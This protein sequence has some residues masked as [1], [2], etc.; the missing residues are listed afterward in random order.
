MKKVHLLSFIIHYSLFII[1]FFFFSLPIH[2][3]TTIDLSGQWQFQIDRNDRGITEGW[4]APDYKFDDSI[5][6][7]ASMPQRLKGDDISVDTK[8]VGSLYDSSYFFNPYMKKYRNPGKDMKL[9]FFLTPDKHYVGVAWYKKTVHIDD[10]ES[11]PLYTLYL[12]RPH[13]T[14]QVWVN[15]EQVSAEQNSLSVPHKHFLYGYLKP[16]DNTIAIRVN[17]DP[18]TVKVGQDSHSVSDQTQGDWNGLVG[19][20][21]LQPFNYIDN[22]KVYPDVDSKTARIHLDLQ[23]LQK[24]ESAIITLKATPFNTTSNFSSQVIVAQ[25]QT[26]ILTDLTSTTKDITLSLGDNMLLWD[27]F[28]PNL[29]R[30]DIE[31]KTKD[32][33][34][35]SSTVFGMRKIEI[36]DK[37]FYV[38]GNEIQLRG[39]V[40]NCDFPLTGYPPTDLESWL[41]V[42]CTCKSYGLNHMR[43]HSYCPPEAAFLAADMVGFYIQPEGPSWPN[44]GVKLGQG[45]PIDTYLMEEALAISDVY[46]NH[47]SFTMFCFGNEPAGNWVKWATEHT[48]KMKVWDDRRVYGGFSVGGGWAWQPGSEYQVKAGARGLNEW[49]KRAPESM[50]D[51]RNNIA[52]YNGKD[53]PGTKIE[54]PYVSHET[55]Q[56][57]A[58]PNFDEIS[59]YSGV[60]KAK[61]FEI[62]RD[63]LRDN[64]MESRAHDFLMA[65]GKL[66][67]ICYKAEIERTLRTP[68]YAGFQLLSLNDYSGQGTA[69]VGLTDVFFDDK[70]YINSTEFSEFCSSV[71]PLARI[72]KFTYTNDEKFEAS[73][74]L[75]QF[76]GTTLKG[77][78]PHWV[79]FKEPSHRTIDGIHSTKGALNMEA[80]LAFGDLPVRDLPIGSNID[81]GTISVPL[82]K[83]TEPTKLTLAVS[84]PNNGSS[85]ATP[86]AMNRWSFWVYPASAG[87]NLPSHVMKTVKSGKRTGSVWMGNILITDTLD[88]EALKALNK[89]KNVLICAAGKVSY[90]KE[91]VQQFTPVFWNTSWFKMRPPH[92]TGIYVENTHDIFELFPTDYHSDL[93]WWELVNRAQVMQFTDFPRDFQPLVQSI[94]TWFV[95]RKIGMLFEARVGKGKLVMTSMD[96][97]NNLDTRHA[98]RQ[99]RESIINYMSSN[100]FQPQWTLSADLIS[101]LF[102]KVAGEVSMFTKDSPDELKPSLDNSIKTKK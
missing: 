21:E 24:K 23:G 46:G 12:E 51:F 98:A 44:H 47:P 80:P 83:I 31:V 34:T 8:W 14:T 27:E 89:G 13:I 69:L 19:K 3:Q 101:D 78:S 81:L 70:G 64:G 88:T 56:W 45:Q 63:L 62:F 6:L 49:S 42:F 95:S 96:I 41:K 36:K 9:Q 59:K 38:N 54:M 52:M 7:P 30:L 58:F 22:V 16:G 2:A 61:N 102:T 68:K 79:I 35:N 67:A 90:G 29:Y 97:T 73:I 17:N 87:S 92:T 32:R 1:Q 84:I 48:A 39:T 91:V 18:E 53:A 10:T 15:G 20:I 65:S 26:A 93:Q 74:E 5:L 86:L 75:S 82:D 11:L 85:S 71:V 99:L 50:A 57:C 33:T 77:V 94:D 40:E 4:W 55:G 37:M 66:Q 100:K 25:P 28:H 60:N 76:S 43:F 72:P